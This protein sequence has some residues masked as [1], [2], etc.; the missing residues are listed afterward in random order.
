MA[1][2]SAD[3]DGDPESSGHGNLL[4][5]VKDSEATTLATDILADGERAALAFCHPSEGCFLLSLGSAIVAS[6]HLDH[7]F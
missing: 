3:L 2:F 6:S 1:A 4:S 5:R 7:A